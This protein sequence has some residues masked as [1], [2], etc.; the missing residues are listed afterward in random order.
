M[1][2]LMG[3]ENDYQKMNFFAWNAKN[4]DIW[5]EIVMIVFFLH[6]NNRI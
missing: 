3:I 1:N 4:R 2:L 6:E 5:F